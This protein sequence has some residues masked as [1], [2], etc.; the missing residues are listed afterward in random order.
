MNLAVISLPGS[1]THLVRDDI[2]RMWKK[3]T[4]HCDLEGRDGVVVDHHWTDEWDM[5]L[6]LS[7]RFFTIVPMRHPRVHLNYWGGMS[8]NLTP[9][10]LLGAWERLIDTPNLHFLPIDSPARDTWLAR[11][12]AASGLQLTTGWP[13]LNKGTTGPMSDEIRQMVLPE[14]IS[15]FAMKYWGHA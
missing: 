3:A 4:I 10:E 14:K 5:G 13:V 7:R 12:N 2:L 15:A 11:I 8:Y 9:T 6:A 1:G